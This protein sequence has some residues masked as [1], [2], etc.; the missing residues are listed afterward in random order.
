MART[1]ILAAALLAAGGGATQAKN[2]KTD[3]QGWQALPGAQGVQRLVTPRVDHA[4]LAVDDARRAREGLPRRFAQPLAQRLTPAVHGTWD[5]PTPGLRRWRLQVES[6]GALSLNLGFGRYRLPQ[7]AT[8][9]LF[10]ANDALA[11]REFTAADNEEHGQLWTPVVPGSVLT[12]ELRV[13]AAAVEQVEL[14]LTSINHGYRDFAET[15]YEKSGACNIDVVCPQGGA[16]RDPIRS[17]VALHYGGAIN[18]SGALVNNTGQNLKGY[19]LTAYHCGLT[20]SNAASLVAYFNFEN[21]TCRPPATS[22]GNG[23]GPLTDFN[24]GAIFR[25]ARS[26]SD[27][28][29]LE[30]DDPVDPAFD[31]YWA[32]FDARNQA[33][34]SAVG[35]HHPNGDEKRISFENQATSITS[36]GGSSTPGDGTHLRVADWDLGV[37][38]PG[39]S[40]SPL[41]S[42]EQRIVG[43]LHGGGSAC[44]N[45]LPDWYGRL[46]ASWTGGGSNATRLSNW[47]D[48]IGSGATLVLDGRNAIESTPFSVAVTPESA[49][50]CALGPN[51]QFAVSVTAASPGSTD[52]VTLSTSGVPAGLGTAISPNPR[53]PG[54]NATLTLS[55]LDDLAPGN[56]SLDVVGTRGA[57]TDSDRLSFALATALPTVPTLVAPANGASGISPATLSWNA[58]AQTAS[59]RV[60]VST[61][62]TF[63]DIVLDTVVAGT[64]AALPVLAR[65]TT[66]YWRV[67]A[68]NACGTGARSA[69]ANFTTNADYCLVPNLAIPDASAGGVASTQTLSGSAPIA[70]LELVLQFEHPFAG[71]LTA[72]LTHA[73]VVDRPLF[74]PPNSCSGHDPDVLLDDD[75]TLTVSG[76][77]ISGNLPAYT[78]GTAYRPVQ[79]LS[80]FD[81]HMLE[82]SWKLEVS[83]LSSG[84]VGMLKR[85]C[86]RPIFPA[87]VPSLFRDG[88]ED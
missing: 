77:C 46:A 79:T 58:V 59:Y 6:P 39:S 45:D 49:T 44:G 7:G 2:P 66:H 48:P 26:Q 13:P 24:S 50:L 54:Q 65:N 53:A 64:S 15:A 27:F 56:Y 29:L 5:T 70:E 82:G 52:P 20:S 67:A 35:I 84:D 8:L 76:N 55:H 74:D 63:A 1:M 78:P 10:D 73:N 85:W 37:T 81:G 43:Q 23:D 38:E 31:V 9:R 33:T 71:D 62:P 72:R 17:V 88:F 60:E 80:V 19:L 21:S 87:P 47:L 25:A 16:W 51:P 18:C 42:P 86:L 83:D 75:A 57:A 11:M 12:V 34:G 14:E 36:Y 30:L 28:T 68:T 41:F 3:G 32:G 22:G 4:A 40:G 69:V 61:D